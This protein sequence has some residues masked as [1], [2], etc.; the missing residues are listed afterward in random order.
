M[1]PK[2]EGEEQKPETVVV[3]PEEQKEP[4]VDWKAEKAALETQLKQAEHTIITLKKKPKEDGAPQIDVEELKEEMRLEAERLAE[5]K[6]QNFK[7]EQA[8]ADV[9]EVLSSLI[10]DPDKREVVRLIYEK[11]IQK[12]G[13]TRSQILE[14]IRA[15]ELLADK[16]RIE[17]KLEE[18]KAAQIS[19]DS[20]SGGQATGQDTPPTTTDLSAEEEATVKSMS[21]RRGISEDVVRKTFIANKLQTKIL[22]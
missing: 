3:Q 6:L 8:Q 20:M 16:P 11:R 4:A 17:K 12:S 1:D 22:Q 21:Q 18:I 19:K 15:A 9:S 13:L 10:T 5:E 14:D 2:K 7:E